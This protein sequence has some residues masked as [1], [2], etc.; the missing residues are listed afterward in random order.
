[1]GAL[2]AS[3]YVSPV[4]LL[5][6][7]RVSN[8]P[9]VWT[10]VVAATVLAGGAL[11]ST[12]T[13]LAISAMTLFYVAGMYLNDAFDREW[14]AR[15][16]PTRPIPA[17]E[18]KAWTVFAAG[19]GMLGLGLAL[20][21]LGDSQVAAAGTAL[22]GAIILYDWWHKG[23]PLSPLLMGGC[24]VLVYVVAAA[25]A[26][27]ALPPALL[28]AGTAMLA[29]VAGLTYAAKQESLNRLGNQ[30]PLVLLAIPLLLTLP[31][32]WSGLLV[33]TLAWLALA[34]V[35]VL[36]VQRMRRLGRSG[37]PWAVA[38]LI[39]AISL[40]D[41]LLVADRFPGVALICASGYVVTLIFQ[42]YIDGT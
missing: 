16:R 7:G 33:P 28:I 4:T 22:A 29:H 19:F 24:R 34:T 39:A 31:T 3:L 5:R 42:R 40:V 18:I 23:N 38:N 20:M 35:D 21:P 27:Q 12:T 32:L 6:L 10:N 25:M 1:M 37:V 30:W 26:S 8:L 2:P 11:T 15:E 17:G 13:L 14:D 9:T 36:A 41:A